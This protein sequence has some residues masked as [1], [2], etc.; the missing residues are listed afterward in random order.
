MTDILKP[1]PAAMAKAISESARPYQDRGYRLASDRAQDQLMGRTHY[2]DPDSLRFHKSRVLDAFP[3]LDGLFYV[4]R[5]SVE[6]DY[7][8][9]TRG[10]RYVVFN[11]F[12]SVVSRNNL[13]TCPRTRAAARRQFD[14][15]A[16]AF[17]A[18]AHYREAL[19]SRADRMGR[20]AMALANAAN[21]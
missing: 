13:D 14:A 9:T 4:I 2:V 5:E 1:I 7:Q 16:A 18:E 21:A 3:M 15:W 11:V 10:Q 20:E 17:D 19:L 8:N 12:G 6:L